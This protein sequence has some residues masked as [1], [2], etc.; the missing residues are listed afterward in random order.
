ML[1]MSNSTLLQT[2]VGHGRET[3]WLEFKCNYAHPE[4]IGEY[5][6]AIANSAALH[7]RDEGFI[8]WGVSDSPAEII[9]TDFDPATF[10]VSGG[11]PLL[12]HLAQNLSPSLHLNIV[13]G[14]INTK[15]VV[16]LRVPAANGLPVSYRGERFIRI[17]ESKTKL[18]GRPEESSLFAKLSRAPFESGAAATRLDESEL[19]QIL[20]YPAYFELMR[21][22]L[23]E[24]RREILDRFQ[25]DRLARSES[26]GWVITNLGALLFARSLGRFDTLARKAVRVVVYRGVD[27]AE[28]ARQQTGDQGYAAGYVGLIKWVN[29]QIPDNVHISQALRTETK[30]YPEIALRELIANALIHQDFSISGTGP[31]IEIFQDRIEIS[32]PGTPLIDP[33]RFLDMPPVSRNERLASTMRR[34]G[35][36]E[37]LG[38]GIDRVLAAIEMYQLPAPEFRATDR[39]TCATLHAPRTFQRMNREERIRAAY[40]HAGLMYVAHRRM[41]NATLRARFGLDAA[42]Y[43]KASAVIRDALEVGVIRHDDPSNKAPRHAKYIPFWAAGEDTPA[44]GSLR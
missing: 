3:A 43:T 42:E 30:M 8:V 20:D 19:L 22:P 37:E 14:H 4:R 28:I 2:L 5:I 15:R 12:I 40:Q 11:Q 1:H 33:I 21:Q 25:A 7:D 38:S 44:G 13:E 23:P 6:S 24:T 29:D 32:N 9:G 39:G 31:L 26:E 16:A 18:Q 41:T 35:I 17:G 36:C 27:R 10:K 34:M